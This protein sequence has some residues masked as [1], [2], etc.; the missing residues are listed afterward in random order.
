MARGFYCVACRY[1]LLTACVAH[2]PDFLRV[3]TRS[4]AS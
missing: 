1:L 3:K 4:T 2:G